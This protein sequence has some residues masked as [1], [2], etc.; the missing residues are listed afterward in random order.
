MYLFLLAD[1]SLFALLQKMDRE[2]A[3]AARRLGCPYCGCA[4]HQANFPRKP[5]GGPSWIEGESAT[6]VTE[7]D[8]TEWKLAYDLRFGLCCSKDG[9]RRRVTP[10]SVRFLGRRIYLGVV[11]VVL[12]AMLNGVTPSG[13][14]QL[15]QHVPVSRR[16]LGRWRAWWLAT[17]VGTPLWKTARAF[18]MP[19]VA[20][21]HLPE[22]LLERFSGEIGSRLASCVLLLG[23]LTTRSCPQSAT[24]GSPAW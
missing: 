20:E 8:G 14:R 7:K 17:F 16:T 2:M 15:Q 22:S 24:V 23:P 13:V 6:V 18:W 19:P 10:A 5:R 11:L 12:S 4:L 1:S 3:E 9:C 21:D